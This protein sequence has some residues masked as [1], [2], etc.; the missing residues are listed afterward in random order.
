METAPSPRQL[1]PGRTRR[2]R[3]AAPGAARRSEPTAPRCRR[4]LLR[5]GSPPKFRQAAGAADRRPRVLSF[6]PFG[7]RR[8]PQRRNGRM[9]RVAMSPIRSPGRW[10]RCNWSRL[11]RDS[12]SRSPG[13]APPAR[14]SVPAGRPVGRS[15]PWRRSRPG[16]P[17]MIEPTGGQGVDDFV[18]A[19]LVG[20]AGARELAVGHERLVGVAR[21]LARDLWRRARNA[22][23]GCDGA[24]GRRSRAAPRPRRRPVAGG[25]DE[26]YLAVR[27]RRAGRHTA[28]AGRCS[29]SGLARGRG[30]PSRSDRRPGRT[31]LPRDPGHSVP[32]RP[33]TRATHD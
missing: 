1:S 27:E 4:Q 15:T 13:S 18:G 5:A 30:A 26:A 14:P 33:S 2:C 28:V 6:R 17:R 25:R 21:E 31:P 29:R 9:A 32:R 24:S 10:T 7:V 8:S 11:Y 12:V 3:P 16:S 19:L 22:S 20:E 23:S